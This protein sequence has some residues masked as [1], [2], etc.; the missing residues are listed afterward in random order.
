MSS[1]FSLSWNIKNMPRVIDLLLIHGINLRLKVFDEWAVWPQKC[2]GLLNWSLNRVKRRVV[3]SYSEAPSVLIK[4]WVAVWAIK[5]L[6]T[7]MLNRSLAIADMCASAAFRSSR[8]QSLLHNWLKKPANAMSLRI[9]RFRL[10]CSGQ[11]SDLHLASRVV[12]CSWG[13]STHSQQAHSVLSTAFSVFPS[14]T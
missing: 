9:S 1:R 3:I 4:G 2:C 8:N 12:R 6:P 13:F 5:A 14:C 7:Y 10:I 11:T